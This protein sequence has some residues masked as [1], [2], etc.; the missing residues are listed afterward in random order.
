ME[1]QRKML[2]EQQEKLPFAV[3]S[4]CGSNKRETQREIGRQGERE[5]DRKTLPK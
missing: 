5:R 3:A 4:E 1:K 2:K